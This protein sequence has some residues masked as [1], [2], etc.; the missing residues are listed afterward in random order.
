MGRGSFIQAGKAAPN[1][2]Q[3]SSHREADFNFGETFVSENEDK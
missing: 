2:F 3:M 1:L